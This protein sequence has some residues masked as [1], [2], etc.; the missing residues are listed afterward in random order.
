MEDIVSFAKTIMVTR[1]AS[2]TQMNEMSSRSHCLITITLTRNNT[3]GKAQN[4]QF[5]FADLGGSE[6]LKKS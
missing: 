3:N 1:I 4:N 6:R 5:I 2:K